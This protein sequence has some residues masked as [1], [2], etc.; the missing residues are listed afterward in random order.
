MWDHRCKEEN[1]WECALT[2]QLNNYNTGDLQIMYLG[3]VGLLKEPG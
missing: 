3:V 1:L 2:D